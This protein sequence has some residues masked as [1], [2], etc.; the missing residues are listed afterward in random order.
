MRT[1]LLDSPFSRTTRPCNPRPFLPTTYIL[2][3][4]RKSPVSFFILRFP[5]LLGLFSSEC[6][7]P[8]KRVL[9][10]SDGRDLTRGR[11]DT[12][13]D[14]GSTPSRRPTTPG[15][16]RSATPRFAR[17]TPLHSHLSARFLE[18]LAQ[19]HLVRRGAGAWGQTRTAPVGRTSKEQRPSAEDWTQH[20]S[21][22]ATS[23]RRR[24]LLYQKKPSVWETAPFFFLPVFPNT[25][26]RWLRFSLFSMKPVGIHSAQ[27]LLLSRSLK[28]LVLKLFRKS[29]RPKKNP[30]KTLHSSSPKL[31]PPSHVQP[32]ARSHV[33][34]S[35]G[36]TGGAQA[37]S[38]ALSLRKAL[39]TTFRRSKRFLAA[40]GVAWPAR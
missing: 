37:A 6:F 20:P 31:G 1:T 10:A 22:V 14:T 5:L 30:Q 33:G 35:I 21:S 15:G 8:V 38:R 23:L 26:I 11:P 40:L 25:F 16:L 12:R 18:E 29:Q 19:Q 9:R 34:D 39:E 28:S 27:Q 24:S 36:P 2:H 13:P 32:K 17:S 7:S 3:N 4:L